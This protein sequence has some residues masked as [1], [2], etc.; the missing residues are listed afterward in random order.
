MDHTGT[1]RR[2]PPRGADPAVALLLLGLLAA[3]AGA[4]LALRDPPTDPG[5]AL[6]AGALLLLGAAALHAAR[7]L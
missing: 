1:R 3:T 4:V 2:L 6:L 5:L 7:R